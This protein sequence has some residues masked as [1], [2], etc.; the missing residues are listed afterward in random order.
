MKHC[1]IMGKVFGSDE[2]D[3]C[4]VPSFNDLKM[5]RSNNILYCV[6]DVKRGDGFKCYVREGNG[7]NIV[8]WLSIREY[9]DLKREKMRV[10]LI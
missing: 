6:I 5:E 7:F 10:D 9:V 3:L 4:I 8:G 2:W 1:N